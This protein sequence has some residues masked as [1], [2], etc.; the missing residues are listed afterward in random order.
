MADPTETRA[1]VRRYLDA[2]NAS[3]FD[4]MEATLHEDV[5]HDVNQGEREVGREA[6]RR[7]NMEMA[8]HYDERLADIVVMVDEHGTRAAAEFTVRG[9]YRETAEG[10]PPAA[11][12]SY[13]LPAG[14]FFDIEDGTISR[15]STYY[16]LS[17]WKRQVGG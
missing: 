1:L 17:E 5:A 9:V 6:F 10:M 8:R 14:I 2:F 16:N 11:D 15:V 13:S 12:Q 7:F 3:D 4:A